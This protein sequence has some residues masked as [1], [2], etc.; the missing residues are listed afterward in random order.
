[1]IDLLRLGRIGL[2]VSF[3]F[4]CSQPVRAT[5]ECSDNVVWIR[6]DFGSARFSVDVAD[7]PE[8][9]AT[10]LMF[11]TEL[12]QSAGMLFVYDSPRL[13]TFWMRN[14][15]I[16]LDM[17]FI[18]EHGV[19]QHIHHRAKPRDETPISGG[20]GLTHVL[21]INGGLAQDLGLSIGDELSHPS[22][23]QTSATWPC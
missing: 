6:G 4:L 13:L 11:R 16:E 12:P 15:L 18:D 9:R 5:S 10:G 22:F 21:E 14:T 7:D 1:M 23:D 19:V 2:L 17:L 3:V 20:R 8:E